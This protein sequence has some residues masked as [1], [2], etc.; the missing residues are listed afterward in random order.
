[1]EEALEAAGLAGVF[2]DG[3]ADADSFAD[4][5][6][7]AVRNFLAGGA[8]NLLDHF[9][10]Y[11]GASRDFLLFDDFLLHHLADLDLANFFARLPDLGG[12]GAPR[13]S[14]LNRGVF[15][16]AAT[17]TVKTALV[18]TMIVA[19]VVACSFAFLN[20]NALADGL[21]GFGA[22]FADPFAA[23]DLD[24]LL[25]PN[26][27]ADDPF[28]FD[29]LG[30]VNWLADHF[31]DFL[32]DR[33]GHVFVAGACPLFGHG[34]PLF[35]VTYF[36]GTSIR[37]RATSHDG[38]SATATAAISRSCG[39]GAEHSGNRCDG[40]GKELHTHSRHSF[41][42]KQNRRTGHP[43]PRPDI[44][45]GGYSNVFKAIMR[46]QHDNAIGGDGKTIRV[47]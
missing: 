6:G 20:A 17:K 25:F 42:E 9:R 11:I 12:V 27:L 32:H 4:V 8:G 21:A 37:S 13:D 41:V 30:L 43:W 19:S 7:F 26:G 22:L 15:G 14:F 24:F 45:R 38:G 29:F 39:I 40:T 18:S 33:F 3:H 34:L 47:S 2:A 10:L 35:F 28:A 1:V 16:E 23:A 36:G 31:T 46:G 44:S 5:V